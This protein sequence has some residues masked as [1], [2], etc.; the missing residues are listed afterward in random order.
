MP[1][2]ETGHAINVANLQQLISIVTGMGATYDPSNP[3]LKLVGL[4]AKFT[5]AGGS[6]DGLTTKNAQQDSLET[7]RNNLFAPLGSR[8]TKAVGY[9]S[10]TGTAA[11]KIEDAKEFK[12]KIDGKRAKPLPKDGGGDVPA[13]GG[14]VPVPPTPVDL[15]PTKSVSQQSYTQKVEH[16]DGLIEVFKTDALYAPNETEL[17]V[18]GVGGLNT[19]STQLHAA[20]A[21][22]IDAITATTSARQTRNVELYDPTTG[23][24]TV[25]RLVKAYIKGLFGASS[26]QFKQ[27]A[28]IKFTDRG[29]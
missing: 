11:N 10:S 26:P 8:V 27:V 12:R 14:P 23:L 15:P 2:N 22:V 24:V 4:N 7:D 13:G 16:L 9:Y 29:V 21:A 25:A 6:I 1:I 3:L 20:N 18:T 5:S 28:G 17:K 19:Y